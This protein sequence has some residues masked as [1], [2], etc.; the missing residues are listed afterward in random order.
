VVVTPTP[1]TQDR[2]G[3][4]FRFDDNYKA[5][6]LFS[7][8]IRN[9][10]GSGSTTEMELRL[11]EQF[12]ISAEHIST[13]VQNPRYSVGGGASFIRMPVPIYAG[14]QRVAEFSLSIGN[15]RSFVGARV[16]RHGGVAV[17]LAVESRRA[18]RYR[19]G[20]CASL[21]SVQYGGAYPCCVFHCAASARN[22]AARAACSAP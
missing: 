11:G 12:K 10:I 21:T 6:L 1:R 14:D 15:L 2:A 3:F 22:D 5:A 19:S 18:C 16:G 8:V 20:L 4:G 17:E 7:A 9:W 13:S